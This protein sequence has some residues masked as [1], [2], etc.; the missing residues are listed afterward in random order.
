MATV[1]LGSS[2]HW[3]SSCLLSSKQRM[4]QPLFH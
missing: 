1:K 3:S 2:L 4:D